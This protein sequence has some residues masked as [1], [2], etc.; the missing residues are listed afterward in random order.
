MRMRTGRR[1]AE[2]I[3]E[4]KPNAIASACENC[5]S[6]LNDLNEHYSLGV[7]VTSVMDLVANALKP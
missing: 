3:R 7:K 6:Q 5:R 2:Q 4:T 1:K